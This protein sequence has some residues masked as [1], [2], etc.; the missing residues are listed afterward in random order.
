MELGN[1]EYDEDCYLLASEIQPADP[2]NT[3]FDAIT[4]GS[5]FIAFTARKRGEVIGEETHMILAA[6]DMYRVLNE[7]LPFLGSRHREITET[8]LKKARGEN[9]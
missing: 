4:N 7:V 5:K 8:A 6:P 9:A 3:L 1:W 2:R